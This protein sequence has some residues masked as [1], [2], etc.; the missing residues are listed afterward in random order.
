M[1]AQTPVQERRVSIRT[2]LLSVAAKISNDGK[3]WENVVAVD[4][5]VGGLGFVAETEYQAGEK[6]TLVG[7]ASN[8]RRDEDISCEAEVAF[9]GQAPGGKYIY[10]VRFANMSR[11]QQ[12]SLGIFIDWILT[13]FYNE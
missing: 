11:E 4:I 5:S 1:H 10:G 13:K 9:V 7:T 2:N 12:T 8:F 3:N 6:L